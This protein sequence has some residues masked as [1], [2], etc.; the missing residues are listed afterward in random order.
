MILPPIK[1]CH[2]KEKILSRGRHLIL[3]RSCSIFP[4]VREV[5]RGLRGKNID[6]GGKNII[7][8]PPVGFLYYILH[9]FL[10]SYPFIVGVFYPIFSGGGGAILQYIDPWLLVFFY[11]LETFL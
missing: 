11:S 1:H 4:P 6:T 3:F 7:Y 2:K 5:Q 9:F 8:Y 10:S